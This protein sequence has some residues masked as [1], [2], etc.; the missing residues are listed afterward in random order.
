MDALLLIKKTIIHVNIMYLLLLFL[1]LSFE[2]QGFPGRHIRKWPSS[3]MCKDRPS[4]FAD[5]HMYVAKP[6]ANGIMDPGLKAKMDD[7]G[8]TIA[9]WF[10]KTKGIQII[11]EG[12]RGFISDLAEKI[13]KLGHQQFEFVSLLSFPFIDLR[14]WKENSNVT[15]ILF[16]TS[17]F[18]N[19]HS[20]ALNYR[21]IES[22]DGKEK[23]LWVPYVH[24]KERN[25]SNHFAIVGVHVPGCESQNPQSGLEW[26]SYAMETA[27]AK[28]R[29]REPL[30]VIAAGDFNAP[31]MYVEKKVSGK[32]YNTPYP[33]HVNPDSQ[34]GNYDQVVVLEGQTPVEISMLPAS[35][36]SSAS[37][38]LVSSIERSRL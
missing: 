5:T 21:Y 35:E 18:T 26:L 23:K 22:E 31:S 16:D 29:T 33:T 12:T 25:S 27:Q 20:S 3:F 11:V 4:P 7:Q 34:A 36:L 30:N 6:Y 2:A 28:C 19:M 38:I 9:S 14:D 1:V 15:A 17:R 8:D 37:Q 32:L 13:K 24:L 10:V